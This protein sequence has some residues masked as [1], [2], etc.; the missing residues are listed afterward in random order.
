MKD[1]CLRREHIHYKK[2]GGRGITVCERWMK[3]ENFLADMGERP[4]GKTLDRINNDKGYCP[5]NCRWATPKE[6]SRNTHKN[7]NLTFNGQ[8][9]TITEWAELTG[10]LKTTI[11]E[12]L[13]RGWTIEEVLTV[14]PK[15]VA[16]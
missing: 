5:E 10:L 2:Y 11:K 4:A 12:R 9:K 6:Q 15:G 13:R 7:H 8:T 16:L 14:S 1:R 3:F